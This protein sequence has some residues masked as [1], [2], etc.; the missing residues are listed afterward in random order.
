[1]SAITTLLLAASWS[2]AS[3][4]AWPDRVR[5]GCPIGAL[6]NASS[7]LPREL[8]GR[9]RARAESLIVAVTTALAVQGKELIR[10]R[11]QPVVRARLVAADN[12]PTWAQP[13]FATWRPLALAVA[14]GAIG[15]LCA[16]YQH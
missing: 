6:I 2:I 13:L 10:V 3:A 12:S 15:V 9:G 5:R 1:V 14:A 4:C 16:V 8:A 11:R 7:G